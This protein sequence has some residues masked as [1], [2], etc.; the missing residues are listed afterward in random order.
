[1]ARPRIDP[2]VT[3][4]VARA[5]VATETAARYAKQ[6]ASHFGHKAEI[7]TE[8]EGPRIVLTVG[9]CLLVPGDH[10][11]ELRAQSETREGL[12][13]VQKVVGS[14]LERFGQRDGLAVEWVD[15]A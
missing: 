13:R 5:A 3:A 9:S 7:R 2:A 10:A 6:L 12:E 1:M 4:H 15:R 14:H 11:L 8:A